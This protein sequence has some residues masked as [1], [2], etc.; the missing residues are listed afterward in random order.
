MEITIRR[1][2]EADAETVHAILM[3][4]H[5]LAGSM[6]VPFSPL[7][8]T[9][10]R[11]A[12]RSG[13]HQLVA[14]VEGQVVG[15]GEL[16]T[17]PDEARAAHMGEINMVATHA[18]FGGR[19]IGTALMEA[20]IDLADNWLNLKR[21]GLIVFAHNER[22]YRLYE[23]LGFRHEGTSPRFG[24]GDGAWMDAHIMGRLRD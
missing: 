1:V 15:F 12:P 21:L 11:L 17:H 4:P 9:R 7:Q 13:R 5:A 8:Q 20:M 18:E 24:Y 3:S 23:R 14:V 2:E 19:G 16:F 10:E 6:R 22:A